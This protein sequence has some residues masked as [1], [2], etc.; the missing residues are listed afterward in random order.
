MY[1]FLSHLAGITVKLQK[2]AL[3]IVE[4]DEMITDISQMYKREHEDIDSSFATVYTQC[5]DG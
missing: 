1:Q 4:A 3:D 5:E 2:T